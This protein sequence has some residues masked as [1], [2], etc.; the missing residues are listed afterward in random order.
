MKLPL[1]SVASKILEG[2]STLFTTLLG[3]F[4]EKIIVEL[5]ILIDSF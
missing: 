2:L 5:S 1:K 4:S 3:G